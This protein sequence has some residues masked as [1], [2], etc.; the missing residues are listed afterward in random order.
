[1]NSTVKL[2]SNLQP[3]ESSDP[4]Q[5]NKFLEKIV[6][7]QGLLELQK[8][9]RLTNGFT[10]TK[11]QNDIYYNYSQPCAYAFE[12]DMPWGTVND[13]GNIHV[14]CK[15]LNTR[16]EFF[17]GCRP[18]FKAKELD[19]YREDTKDWKEIEER[20][21]SSEAKYKAINPDKENSEVTIS[22]TVSAE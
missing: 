12:E 4:L 21:K 11:L 5:N 16:C 3:L 2:I 20:I 19:Q 13:N 7:P 14:I 9:I 1:M 10:F 8:K 22:S 15:C 18:D 6:D 17:H